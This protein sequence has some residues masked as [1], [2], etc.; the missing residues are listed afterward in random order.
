MEKEFI[1]NQMKIFYM[2]VIILMIIKKEM[3][4][5]FMKKVIII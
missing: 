5:I 4:N 3:E 1:I 2:K